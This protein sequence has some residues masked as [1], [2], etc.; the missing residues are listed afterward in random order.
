VVVSNHAYTVVGTSIDGAGHTLYTLRNPWGSSGGS[1]ENAAGYAT[2]TYAQLQL[3][4][5]WGGAMMA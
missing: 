4:Y 3:Y 5:P 1:A 2:L